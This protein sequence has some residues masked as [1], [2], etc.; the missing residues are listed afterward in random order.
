MRSTQKEE[1]S[2]SITEGEYSEKRQQNPLDMQASQQFPRM[3]LTPANRLHAPH[4]SAS[5]QDDGPR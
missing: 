5:P 1:D 2:L 4:E 3:I